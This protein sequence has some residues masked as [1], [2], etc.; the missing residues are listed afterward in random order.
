MSTNSNFEAWEEWDDGEIEDELL[1]ELA[2]EELDEEVHD[3][4]DE[5]FDDEPFFDDDDPLASGPLHQRTQWLQIRGDL[6]QAVGADDLLDFHFF[7]AG[8]RGVC[9]GERNFFNRMKLYFY[10]D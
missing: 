6:D 2:F 8:T 5:E 9:K 4:S 1:D 3:E 10:K 7:I